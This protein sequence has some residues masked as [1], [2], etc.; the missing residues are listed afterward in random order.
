MNNASCPISPELVNSNLTRTYSLLTFTS[1]ILYVFTPFKEVIYISALD[2]II[3]IFIG[4]KYSP[5]CSIIKYILKI[6]N[7]QSHMVNAG[8]K[9][10]AAKIGMIITSLMSIS[11]LLDLSN[12]SLILG[13]IS[14][15]AVGAEAIFG[16]CV[17]CWMHSK[18]PSFFQ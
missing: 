5:I 4:V 12:T 11:Y 3:R 8:P 16:F 2:F 9:K 6:G 1:I 15:V 17:A 14:L 18:L 7:F 10:F 13:I